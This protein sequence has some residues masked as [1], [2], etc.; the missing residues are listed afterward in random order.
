[1]SWSTISWMISWL[2]DSLL[3]WIF[4]GCFFLGIV[5]ILASWFV[6]FIPII[7]RYR[8]PTQVVGILAY[9]LGAFLIG[10]LGVE[11]GWRERV[12][13]MEKKVAEAEAKSQQVNTVIETKIVEK[14]KVIK[15]KG[16]KQIEYIDRVVK[17]DTTEI[18]KDMSEQERQEFLAKQKQLEDSIKNCPVPEII[19]EELNKAAEPK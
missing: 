15:E 1:M 9:G 17:G 6:S 3:M 8:F 12:A 16:Q 11:L 2:P 10:G 14:V 19:V 4:Y 5:L 18:T 13:E 7:N